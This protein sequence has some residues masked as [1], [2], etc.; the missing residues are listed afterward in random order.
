MVHTHAHLTAQPHIGEH[1]LC[2]MP[3][4]LNSPAH[5]PPIYSSHGLFQS[6]ALPPLI[7]MAPV[8]TSANASSSSFG[9][10]DN[11]PHIP[12]KPSKGTI[13]NSMINFFPMS[14][15]YLHVPYSDIDHHY[16]HHDID[17]VHHIGWG[18]TYQE[19]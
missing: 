19:Q 11:F 9:C 5:K 4:V 15:T 10:I 16:I 6:Y 14:G 18:K 13:N 17:Q 1:Y 3:P 7:I 12:T 8:I 2:Q